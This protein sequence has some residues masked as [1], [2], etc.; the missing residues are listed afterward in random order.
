MNQSFSINSTFEMA[1]LN[2][3]SA[4]E[5]VKN[6][7]IPPSP[8]PL[9]PGGEGKHIEIQKEI[10][11]PSTGRARVGVEGG[12]GGF[13]QMSCPKRKGRKIWCFF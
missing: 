7:E 5:D 4:P 11:S 9:P 12:T 8:Y 13:L 10:S 6:S 2:L 1:L 3:S